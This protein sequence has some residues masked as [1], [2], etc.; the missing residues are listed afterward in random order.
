MNTLQKTI[1]TLRPGDLWFTKPSLDVF[2]DLII[3]MM[4]Y[5]PSDRPSASDVLQ[6]PWFQRRPAL[7]YAPGE[8]TWETIGR[9]R[10]THK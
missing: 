10:V 9:P 3:S 5:R 4:Q 8:M 2:G 7:K 6:H 1:D